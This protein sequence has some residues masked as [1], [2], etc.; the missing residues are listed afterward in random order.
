MYSN[1][2]E[3][4]QTSRD[5]DKYKSSFK[6]VTSVPDA[7]NEIKN[8]VT[9]S[10]SSDK[11]S[12]HSESSFKSEVRDLK[13]LLKSDDGLQCDKLF[14][15]FQVC[16]K[17]RDKIIEKFSLTDIKYNDTAN[18]L[19]L[20]ESFIDFS[21]YGDILKNKNTSNIVSII[22]FGLLIIIILSLLNNESK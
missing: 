18:S 4:W 11:S 1:I 2:D 6:P 3:A 16:K 9:E 22:L 12:R 20:T 8:K 19:R 21:K 7:T 10:E 5:L 14:G 13:R 15:H 17:C